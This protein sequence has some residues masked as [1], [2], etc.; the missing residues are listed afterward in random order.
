MNNSEREE[1]SVANICPVCNGKKTKL[2]FESEDDRYGYPDAFCIYRCTECR[3]AFLDGDF[4]P[5]LLSELY[6]DYYPRANFDLDQF[7][8]HREPNGWLSWFDG[9][10]AHCYPWVANGSRVLDIGCGRCESLE[11]YQRHG[12]EAHGMETDRN[13]EKIAKHFGFNVKI[14]LFNPECFEENYF[15]AVTLDMVIEHI[16]NPHDILQGVRKILKPGGKLIFNY[17]TEASLGRYFF[18]KRWL[19]WHTPYHVQFFSKQ[20]VRR[21]AEKNGFEIV[22]NKSMTESHWLLLQWVMLFVHGRRGMASPLWKTDGYFDA[23]TAKRWDV[24]FY[25]LLKKLRPHAFLTRLADFLGVGDNRIC[26]LVKND[27]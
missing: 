12:C 2:L 24:R 14:G 18:G 15:D 25:L 8:K 6:T 19:H 21:L 11:Y 16:L 5:D 4:T 9:D 22:L 23:S 3:H 10:R 7:R 26:I 17:P 20:S 1:E 13:A 27:S